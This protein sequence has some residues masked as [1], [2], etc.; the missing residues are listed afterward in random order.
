MISPG[1]AN[2]LFKMVRLVSTAARPSRKTLAGMQ[3][4]GYD[5]SALLH[6]TNMGKSLGFV[7][8]SSTL[9]IRP[10]LEPTC[11]R[12]R[13]TGMRIGMLPVVW[14]VLLEYAVILRTSRAYTDDYSAS[15]GSSWH[16]LTL[17]LITAQQ[18]KGQQTT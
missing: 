14:A 15:L 1:P 9:E 17:S 11:A 4:Q 8:E 12:E 7:F 18:T 2:G 6:G 3:T 10:G 13:A 5:C 16:T